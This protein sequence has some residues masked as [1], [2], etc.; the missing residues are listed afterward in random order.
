MKQLLFL[1]GIKRRHP[2]LAGQHQGMAV[3]Q[4]AA[5]PDVVIV[6]LNSVINCSNSL[7]SVTALSSFLAVTFIVVAV[8]V[9]KPNGYQAVTFGF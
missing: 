3:L 9:R 5:F 4:V 1:V 6:L 2:H 8:T 7:S